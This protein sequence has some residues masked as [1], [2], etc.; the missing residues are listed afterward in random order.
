[1]RSFHFVV[2]GL[3][4][5]SAFADQVTLKNGDRLTGKILTSDEKS[6]TLKTDYAGELKIDR[7][8]IT[9][10]QTDEALNVTIKEAGVTKA[11]VETTDGS[12]RVTKADGTTVTVQPE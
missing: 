10:F 2:L 1:M 7:G 11:K 6:L 12:L 8:M 3:I 9:A 4:G 5:L